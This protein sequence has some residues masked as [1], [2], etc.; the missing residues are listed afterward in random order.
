MRDA[1]SWHYKQGQEEGETSEELHIKWRQ[2]QVTWFLLWLLIWHLLG[3]Q[4][5]SVSYLV[6][7]E[8]KVLGLRTSKLSQLIGHSQVRCLTRD[9]EAEKG[10]TRVQKHISLF[11]TMAISTDQ[12][13]LKCVCKAVNPQDINRYNWGGGGWGM[14]LVI[15]SPYK[16][17]NR[18]L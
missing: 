15:K 7:W 10:R 16:N 13:F 3:A 6:F 2:H 14:V 17:L 11:K 1:C 18:F 12:N 5:G 9:R 4:I 8:L